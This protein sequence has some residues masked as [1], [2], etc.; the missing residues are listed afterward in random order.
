MDIFRMALVLCQMSFD[1]DKDCLV[2]DT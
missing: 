2:Q 1:K